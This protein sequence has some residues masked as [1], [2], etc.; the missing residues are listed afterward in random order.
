M[1]SDH[2]VEIESTGIVEPIKDGPGMVQAAPAGEGAGRE[3]LAG[4]MEEPELDEL[5]LG[6]QA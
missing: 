1:S 5:G 2:N 4:K 3:E 6:L